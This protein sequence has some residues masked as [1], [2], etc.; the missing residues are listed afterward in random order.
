MNPRHTVR[1][2]DS[3]ILNGDLCICCCQ[4]G[5]S[6]W[7]SSSRCYPNSV[8]YSSQ[9][10]VCYCTSA[11]VLVDNV[12]TIEQPSSPLFWMPPWRAG[13]FLG[14]STL[15]FFPFFVSHPILTVS[16]VKCNKVR[17]KIWLSWLVRNTWWP[18]VNL[19]TF[20]LQHVDFVWNLCQTRQYK[21]Q[22]GARH[23]RCATPQRQTQIGTLHHHQHRLRTN[24]TAQRF[25]MFFCS[26]CRG[27]VW[28]K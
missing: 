9:P 27:L 7:L 17:R 10:F 15:S 11:K 20:L 21:P 23:S 2:C 6:N 14:S 18:E 12:H 3:D 22:S 26:V 4:I 28:G 25:F 16:V 24:L 5:T 8:V 13:L 19:H 1:L